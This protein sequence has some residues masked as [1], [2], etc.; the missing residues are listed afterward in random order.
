MP[1]TVAMAFSQ[2]AEHSLQLNEN[3]TF[4]GNNIGHQSAVTG[5]LVGEREVGHAK[6]ENRTNTQ[7]G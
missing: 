1:A 4:Q 7:A 5:S 2:D 6:R 3:W